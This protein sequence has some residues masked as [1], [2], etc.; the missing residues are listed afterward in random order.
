MVIYVS[1]SECNDVGLLVCNPCERRAC[2]EED[3]PE[4]AMEV[5]RSSVGRRTV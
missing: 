1:K 3:S 4:R 5:T 2:L